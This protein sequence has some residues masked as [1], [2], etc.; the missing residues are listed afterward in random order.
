MAQSNK[1]HNINEPYE[2]VLSVR[3]FFSFPA[4]CAPICEKKKHESLE[5]KGR[6]KHIKVCVEELPIYLYSEL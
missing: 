5:V 1:F 4:P 6:H 3:V 2:Q